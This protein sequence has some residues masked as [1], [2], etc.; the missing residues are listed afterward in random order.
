MVWPGRPHRRDSLSITTQVTRFSVEQ[1]A[2]I[3][4]WHT[5]TNTCFQTHLNFHENF[6]NFELRTFHAC[7]ADNRWLRFD[8][9]WQRNAILTVN[10]SRDC[11]T[12]TDEQS[13]CFWHPTCMSPRLCKYDVLCMSAVRGVALRVCPESSGRGDVCV[14]EKIKTDLLL[15]TAIHSGQEGIAQEL[16]QLYTTCVIWV[17]GCLKC[18]VSCRALCYLNWRTVFHD[19]VYAPQLR[20]NTLSHW[21]CAQLCTNDGWNC[22]TFHYQQLSTHTTSHPQHRLRDLEARP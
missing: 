17:P 8:Y 7:V 12:C 10:M 2:Q 16:R 22:R 6:A 13:T 3:C 21:E 11:V 14:L 9:V 18:D 15:K 20:T 19:F 1:P 4:L 5:N